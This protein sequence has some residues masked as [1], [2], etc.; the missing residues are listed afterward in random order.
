MVS[1]ARQPCCCPWFRPSRFCQGFVPN[2]STT[3]A[4]QTTLRGSL[5]C[6]KGCGIRQQLTGTASMA[7]QGPL[8]WAEGRGIPCAHH[9]P[10]RRMPEERWPAGCRISWAYLKP[11]KTH[12]YRSGFC[13]RRC[14]RVRCISMLCKME[15]PPGEGEYQKGVHGGLGHPG[16]PRTWPPP[17]TN[18]GQRPPGCDTNSLPP[19]RPL[20]SAAHRAK[21]APHMHVPVCICSKVRQ[22][23]SAESRIQL[24]SGL[25][26]S[27]LG[28]VLSAKTS[29]LHSASW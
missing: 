10:T 6:P 24:S 22:F 19:K 1:A 29:G 25:H 14:V 12:G 7:L 11:L 2:L 16:D 5:R 20:G 13:G 27:L 17:Q 3:L 15:L 4:V 8:C 9:S 23:Q 26:R 28:R 21:S 18:S